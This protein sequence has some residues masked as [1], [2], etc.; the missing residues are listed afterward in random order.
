[1]SAKSKLVSAFILAASTLAFAGIPALFGNCDNDGECSAIFNRSLP[2]AKAVCGE[3]PASVAWTKHSKLLLL[4]CVGSASDQEDDMNY[5]VNGRDV[6]GLNYGR[7]VKISFLEQNP[8]TPVADKFGAVPVCTP[9]KVDKLHV[10][11]FVLL[12][13]RP[14]KSGS[15]SCYDVT[16][17]SAS[18]SNVRLEINE[19]TVKFTDRA[20]FVGHLSDRTRQRI[21]KLIQ[22]FETWHDQQPK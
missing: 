20:H 4:Q 6:V 21:E 15:S 19:G 3:R 22:V 14:D 12:G 11:T 10:S 9:A 17:L 13:K 8:A 7:Y 18:G 16:Y 1:M 2:E 5:L